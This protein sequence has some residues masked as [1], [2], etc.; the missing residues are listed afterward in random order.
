LLTIIPEITQEPR[1]GMVNAFIAVTTA[2][3]L[4]WTW[5]RIE[6]RKRIALDGS[7]ITG[8]IIAMVL[9][10]DVPGYVAA[11]AAAV[12]IAAKHIFKIRKK[13]VLNPAASG[14]LAVLYL[15]SSGQS[16]W[17]GMST[18][19]A[20]CIVFVLIGGFWITHRI[21][22]FP[23]VFAFLGVYFS[24]FLILGLLHL[25]SAGDALRT[26]F[27]HSA[28]FLSLFMLTDPPT[29]PALY[30]E[31]IVFGA[32][33]AVISVMIFIVWGG[34]AYLLIGLLIAN[35]WQGYKSKSQS[36]RKEYTAAAS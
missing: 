31:Q 26:P 14:L 25:G 19:P 20:W 28:I 1:G 36:A 10:T 11:L 35:T 33:A 4:D 29:S 9:G 7:V 5:G 34:E 23:Q 30:R 6:Q 22:K 32:I 27:I 12:G 3:L 17:G 13:P 16:W 8:L 21:N 24:L 18:L 15:F 2:V